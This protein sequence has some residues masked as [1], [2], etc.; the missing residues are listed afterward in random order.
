MQPTVIL[1]T[2]ST[3]RLQ[4]YVKA[5]WRRIT[6]LLTMFYLTILKAQIQTPYTV[7]G[8]HQNVF[9]HLFYK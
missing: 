7:R 5:E 3:E 4:T 9:C 1:T 6:H 2:E 8:K